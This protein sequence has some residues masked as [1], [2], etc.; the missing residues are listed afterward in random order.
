MMTVIGL[1]LG[2]VSDDRRLALGF[3]L[4]GGLLLGIIEYAVMEHLLSAFPHQYRNFADSAIIATG[5]TGMVWLLLAGTRER[6]RRVREELKAIAELNHEIRNALQVI[7]YS[8]YLAQA[9]GRELVGASVDRIDLAL[10]R[11]APLLGLQLPPAHAPIQQ[12]A[13]GQARR[14]SG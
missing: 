6:R 12:M 10:K 11:L 3:S 4:A 14:V 5:A 7:A 1:L 9:N 13:K 8:P 2:K